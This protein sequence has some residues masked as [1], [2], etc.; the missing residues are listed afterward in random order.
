[1][2]SFLL[3]GSFYGLHWY[4][5]LMSVIGP[6]LDQTVNFL[7]G[8]QNIALPILFLEKLIKAVGCSLLGGFI[9]L[10][11]RDFRL[12]QNKKRILLLVCGV[13]F[14]VVLM[15]FQYIRLFAQKL[16]AIPIL[17]QLISCQLGRFSLMLGSIYMYMTRSPF[18][19]TPVFFTVF[20]YGFGILTLAFSASN[21]FFPPT[22]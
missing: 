15:D 13:G 7:A 21:N 4:K 2:V 16:A 14:Y 17:H 22:L 18:F 20:L 8:P 10:C 5:R 1:M 19:Q 3:G 6:A 9:C 11:V 12:S